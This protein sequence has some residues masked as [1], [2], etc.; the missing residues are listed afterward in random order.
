MLFELNRFCMPKGP[1]GQKRAA[2][3]VGCAITVAKIATGEVE[4]ERYSAPGRKKSG[5][6]GAKARAAALTAEQRRAI[7]KKAANVRWGTE[8]E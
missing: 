6:A 3:V 8:T 2:N 7:A 5:E 1:T 4:D